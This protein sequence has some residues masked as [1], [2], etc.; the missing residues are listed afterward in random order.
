MLKKNQK[1]LAAACVS[2]CIVLFLGGYLF[3]GASETDPGTTSANAEGQTDDALSGAAFGEQTPND[4]DM[5]EDE[6]T[7]DV[8][9]DE[10]T[11]DVD[12]TAS[13]VDLSDV[14]AEDGDYLIIAKNE[15]IA[16]Y[17]IDDFGAKQFIQ[18]T[19]IPYGLLSENDQ[20]LFDKGIVLTSLTEVYEL[21]QDFES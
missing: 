15:K 20:K 8:D 9:E 3:F 13:D 16:I 4:S 21:L 12:V 10:E 7:G 11:G 19:D 5:D 2:L 14:D 17:F 6:E 18:Q 1:Y